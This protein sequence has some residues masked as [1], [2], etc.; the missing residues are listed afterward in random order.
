MPA[1]KRSYDLK[2][3][4]RQQKTNRQNARA[5]M[6]LKQE[7]FTVRSEPTSLSDFGPKKEKKK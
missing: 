6:K 7:P 2:K 3:L 5:K 4:K 1:L